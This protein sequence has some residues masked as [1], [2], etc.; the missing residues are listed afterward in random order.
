MFTF[1]HYARTDMKKKRFMALGEKEEDKI[2][3]KIFSGQKRKKVR[4]V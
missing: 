2:S 4:G 1:S 3:L